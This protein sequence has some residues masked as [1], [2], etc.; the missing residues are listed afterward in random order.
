MNRK[1]I[2]VMA[3][4]Q[5]ILAIVAYISMGYHFNNDAKIFNLLANT[6][7]IATVLRLALYA[8]P[9]IHLL[10]GLYGLVFSD[11]G[12]LLVIAIVEAISCGLSFLYVGSSQYMFILSIVSSSIAAIYLISALTIK[13]N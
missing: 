11:K 4:M 9:G 1:I 2:K 8:V 12:I 6:D 5:M 3:V 10:A 13:Q 7:F